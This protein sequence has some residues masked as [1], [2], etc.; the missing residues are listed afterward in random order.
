MP[1]L[2]ARRVGDLFLGRGLERVLYFP[3]FLVIVLVFKEKF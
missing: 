3:R 2:G 1:W